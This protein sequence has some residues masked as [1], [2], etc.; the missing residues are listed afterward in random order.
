MRAWLHPIHLPARL[1]TAGP[2][3]GPRSA[4]ILQ[5]ERDGLCGLGEAAP[6]PAFGGEGF[7]ACLA[8]LRG[9]LPLLR[10]RQGDLNRLETRLRRCPAARQAV[11]GAL[12][13][14]A[15][16]SRGLALATLLVPGC[17]LTVHCNWLGEAPEP[18][19]RC[20]KIK[21][22]PD[23]LACA[24]RLR[25]L[26]HRAPGLRLR[27]DANGAW[28]PQA[29]LRFAAAVAGL[30]IDLVE[31]PCAPRFDRELPRLQA[32]GGLPIALDE[33]LRCPADAARLIALR[34]A[35]LVL[36]PMLLGGADRCL[37]IARRA[38]AAGLRVIVSD[39]VCSPVGRRHAAHCA[40]ACDP[41][42]REWHGLATA[43]LLGE[44]DPIHF[45]SWR[46][47]GLGCGA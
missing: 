33:S 35:A 20:C 44:R 26:H 41:Q 3:L 13:D 25:A 10:A 4:V 39:A 19:W 30:P 27:L 47:R 2:T 5:V 29:Y 31:Q 42:A 43:P 18:G 34:P 7:Q 1:A 8:A 17:Q 21:A 38:R 12:L 22:L 6:L 28:S 9:C 11:S 14:L 46:L 16:R 36:K 45:G 23:P 32:L 24:E 40:A 15:A 37:E